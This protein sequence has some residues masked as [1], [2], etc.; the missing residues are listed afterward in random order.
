MNG[1][2]YQIGIQF[3]GLSALS[4][5]SSSLS[6]LTTAVNQLNGHLATTGTRFGGLGNMGRQATDSLSNGMSNL[7]QR[8][9]GVALALQSFA[10]VADFEG[11]SN[12]ILFAGGNEGATNLEFVKK[13]AIDLRL[14]IEAA[15]E[16]FKSLTGSVMGTTVSMTQA[17]NVFFGVSEAA[18]VM[19]LNSEQTK[20][21]FAALGQMASKGG[22]MAQ[23]LKLQLGERLPGAF[24]LAA[25]AMG[26]STAKLTEIMG[27]GLD[28]SAF[29]S[30]L[31]GEM[32]KTFKSGVPVALT[33]SR[34]QFNALGNSLTQLNLTIGSMVMPTVLGLLNDY[35]IPSVEWMK[36]NSDMVLL[37][38]GSIAFVSGVSKTWAF[39]EMISVGA[40]AVKNA[41]MLESCGIAG[42]LSVMSLIATSATGAF[43]A[44]T[45]ALNAAFAA[46]PIGVVV[47]SLGLLTGAIWYAWNHFS[48]F[49]A[50]LYGMWAVMK[51]T[52]IIIYETMIRPLMGLGKILMGVIAF[53]SW[54]IKDGLADLSK[55]IDSFATVTASR[56]ANA[57]S[58]GW[59]DGMKSLNDASKKPQSALPVTAGAGSP[60]VKPDDKTKKSATHIS[61]GGVRNITINVGKLVEHFEVRTTNIQGGAETAKDIILR[62]LLQVVN[63]ANQVQ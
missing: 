40:L 11:L 9:G 15:M 2:S 19:G 22:V 1:F 27:E 52:G 41:Y 29:L 63:A 18:L 53:D 37:L 17:R 13:T 51:E 28:P 50:F 57:F 34:A 58:Q 62:E 4:Q 45:T 38:G 35:I 48:G 10:K 16:G 47:V 59:D 44:A 14:P 8:V 49:R 23:E 25:R 26:V 60:S 30:K 31:S 54:M 55:T 43:T 56:F 20:G 6:G 61:Q 33:S 24:S 39:W 36:R 7:L 12:A 32:D 21:V 3:Q 42:T 46:N 5:V